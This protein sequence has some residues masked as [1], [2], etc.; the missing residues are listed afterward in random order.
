MSNQSHLA[1]FCIHNSPTTILITF[2]TI[3]GIDEN[4]N[5]K[6]KTNIG[7]EWF[8]EELWGLSFDLLMLPVT[9]KPI[10]LL[11]ITLEKNET[12]METK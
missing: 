3:V 5:H 2:S 7:L 4:I 8:I 9:Y 6:I 10:T 12:S 11:L 1:T